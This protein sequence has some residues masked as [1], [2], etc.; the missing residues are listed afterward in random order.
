M[1]LYKEME[2]QPR[3]AAGNSLLPLLHHEEHVLV[4][5]H[6]H[7]DLGGTGQLVLQ[8]WHLRRT[9]QRNCS[10]EN[11]ECVDISIYMDVYLHR[12]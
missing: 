1:Y 8:R 10:V 12:T 9:R 4:I 2:A 5:D 6:I 7:V 3:A 11:N